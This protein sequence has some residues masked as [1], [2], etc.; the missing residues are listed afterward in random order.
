M[1]I[2]SGVGRNT[3]AQM[4]WMSSAPAQKKMLTTNI[5]AVFFDTNSLPS[6]SRH[7]RRRNI[8]GTTAC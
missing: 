6:Y 3:M 1:H 7:D 4:R 8:I 2:A 5:V